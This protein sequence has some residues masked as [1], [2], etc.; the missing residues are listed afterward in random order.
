ML[1]PSTISLRIQPHQEIRT[2]PAMQER[3]KVR[4]TQA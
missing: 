2:N 4:E 1:P 3:A